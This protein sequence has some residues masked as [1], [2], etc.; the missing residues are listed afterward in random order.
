MLGDDIIL[1]LAFCRIYVRITNPVTSIPNEP[2]VYLGRTVYILSN[3][4]QLDP[5]RR[6]ALRVCHSR[7]SRAKHATHDFGRRMTREYDCR[8]TYNA[9]DNHVIPPPLNRGCR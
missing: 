8:K 4:I 6:D 9:L 7:A 3:P 2:S 5:P 1:S